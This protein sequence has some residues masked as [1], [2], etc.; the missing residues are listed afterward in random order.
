MGGAKSLMESE[1][2]LRAL[3]QLPQELLAQLEQAAH[4]F[5]VVMTDQL[6]AQVEQLDQ[7]LGKH[8]EKLAKD[9]EHY[10]IVELIQA[11]LK[12]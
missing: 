4:L 12:Y 10:K 11:A 5:D 3:A 2:D 7:N 8:L 9:F 1:L 6:I